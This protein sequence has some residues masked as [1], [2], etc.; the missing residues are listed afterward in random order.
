MNKS[1]LGDYVGYS[2]GEISPFPELMDMVMFHELCHALHELEGATAYKQHKLIPAFYKLSED[3]EKCQE[4]CKAWEND[5]EIRT[6]TGWYVDDDGQLK[7]D[8][9]NTNSY[10][11][12]DAL[13]DKIPPEQIVQRVFHCDYWKLMRDYPNAKRERLYALVIPIEKYI[14]A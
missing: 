3:R 4:T 6:I 11:I 9:L 5:E 14:D 10:M 12:L 13:K 2:A 8:W 1:E 7:F